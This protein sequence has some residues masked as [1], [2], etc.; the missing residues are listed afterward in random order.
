MKIAVTATADNLDAQVDGRFG[1]AAWFIVVDTDSLEFEAIDNSAGA[2]AA[3]GAGVQAA[4]VISQSGAQWLLTGNCG[5][6]AFA[7]LNAAGVKVGI[8]AEGKVSE[9]ID[10]FKSGGFSEAA[11]P[12]V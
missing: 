6:K 2:A 12:N 1:R 7:G 4:M 11:A 10:R 9:T 8:G 5:P 3:S